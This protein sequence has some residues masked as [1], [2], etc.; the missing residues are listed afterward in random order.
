MAELLSFVNRIMTNPTCQVAAILSAG[1]L[2]VVSAFLRLLRLALISAIVLLFA[3]SLWLKGPAGERKIDNVHKQYAPLFKMHD[4]DEAKAKWVPQGEK[5]N[6]VD[7]DAANPSVQVT[8]GTVSLFPSA[9]LNSTTAH[10][11]N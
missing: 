7:S 9:I 6:G 4:G 2:M 1:S 10:H 5:N 3:F 8:P 11:L